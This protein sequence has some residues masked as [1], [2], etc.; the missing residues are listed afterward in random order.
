[1]KFKASK[2]EIKNGFNTVFSVGYCDMSR[3]FHYKDAIAY[4]AGV[5]G[6]ACDY[7]DI[8]SGVCI[9]TGY[10]PIGIHVKRE[11]TEKY[12]LLAENILNDRMESYETKEEKLNYLIGEFRQELLN[13]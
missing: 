11:L 3:L 9:S 13:Q 4:S 7:Y 5:Y 12:E 8:G 10:S 1:M 2:Q 6:W